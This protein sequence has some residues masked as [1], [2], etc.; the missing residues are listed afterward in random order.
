M[1]WN[2]I[3][4]HDIQTHTGWWL[5]FIT[6][7]HAKIPSWT[8]FDD[9]QI[10]IE[11]ATHS[12]H[13]ISGVYLITQKKSPIYFH[14]FQLLP[15]PTGMRTLHLKTIPINRN[16][17]TF[18]TCHLWSLFNYTEKKSHLFPQVP[19]TSKSH[20][21]EN[22]PLKDNPYNFAQRLFPCFPEKKVK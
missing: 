7:S 3:C 15:N 18:F 14:K 21:Y 4:L 19:I 20:W 5:H 10:S 16:C 13:V 8:W 12:L 22:S 11:T 17:N 1:C 6:G 2:W 9:G